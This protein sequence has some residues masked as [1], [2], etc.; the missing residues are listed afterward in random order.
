MKH[1]SAAGA[2]GV[3][4]QLISLPED[5]RGAPRV[6]LEV[7]HFRDG[8]NNMRAS[9]FLHRCLSLKLRSKMVYLPCHWG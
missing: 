5:L 2:V 4:H 1:V 9:E 8:S 6:S 7:R 3:V